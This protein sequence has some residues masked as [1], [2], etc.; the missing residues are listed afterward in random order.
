[1][2]RQNIAALIMDDVTILFVMKMNSL[3]K[4]SITEKRASKQAKTI[5]NV[6][7]AEIQVHS[8]LCRIEKNIFLQYKYYIRNFLSNHQIQSS[9][10]C[11]VTFFTDIYEDDPRVSQK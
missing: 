8:T 3:E 6:Q 2:I 9:T 7:T 5:K 11:V 10:K 1:M 4:Y